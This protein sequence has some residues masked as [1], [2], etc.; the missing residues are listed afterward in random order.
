MTAFGG[1]NLAWGYTMGYRFTP[2]KPITV[3]ALGGAYYALR[4]QLA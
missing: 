1:T 2:N 4:A 3:T